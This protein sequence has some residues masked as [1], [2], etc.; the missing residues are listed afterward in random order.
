MPLLTVRPRPSV[1]LLVTHTVPFIAYP[2]Q[3]PLGG[4]PKKHRRNSR[5]RVP[6][7]TAKPVLSCVCLVRNGTLLLSIQT[8]R[9]LLP[10][11][12]T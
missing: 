10:I 4:R 1:A 8:R 3:L 5:T 2:T 7:L 9:S 11:R 6:V 12:E